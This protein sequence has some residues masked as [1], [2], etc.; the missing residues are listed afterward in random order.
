MLSLE[1]VLYSLLAGFMVA[2][3]ADSP[4]DVSDA[5]FSDGGSQMFGDLHVFGFV[6]QRRLSFPGPMEFVSDMVGSC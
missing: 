6:C 4:Y 1:E 2:A 5:W 3:F